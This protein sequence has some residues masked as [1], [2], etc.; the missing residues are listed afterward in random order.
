[1]FQMWVWEQAARL[2]W[3]IFPVKAQ[4]ACFRFPRMWF[5]CCLTVSWW[6]RQPQQSKLFWL[7][8]QWITSLF[9]QITYLCVEFRII[10][11]GN[12][13]DSIKYFAVLLNSQK[14]RA[15][16][17]CGHN[18]LC[19]LF[20]Q[21]KNRSDCKYRYLLWEDSSMTLTTLCR[22]QARWMVARWLIDSH[23]MKM[24][25]GLGDIVMQRFHIAYGSPTDFVSFSR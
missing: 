10:A 20:L 9:C 4:L 19:F 15:L 11:L 18:D 22:R 24:M 1:M 2:R 6:K 16:L 13:N 12:I 3:A 21:L 7:N 5:L 14:D 17:L 25:D 23:M 8:D